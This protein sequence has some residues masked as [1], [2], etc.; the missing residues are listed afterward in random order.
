VRSSAGDVPSKL[1]RY[2]AQCAAESGL[3]ACVRSSSTSSYS[4][5]EVFIVCYAKSLLRGSVHDNSYRALIV[6]AFGRLTGLG[7]N[8]YIEVR[9]GL[10]EGPHL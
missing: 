1:M 2:P 5:V 9:F 8:L 4:I 10:T 3:I 7:L 6:N